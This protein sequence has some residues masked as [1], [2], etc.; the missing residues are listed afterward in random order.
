MKKILLTLFILTFSTQLLVA[1]NLKRANSLFERRA[2]LNAAELYLN[3]APKTQEIYQK[4]GDCYYF[5][6]KMK[7][8]VIYYDILIDNYEKTV[9]PT[10]LFRYSQALKG[11]GN[12]NKADK[13]L[14][15]YYETKQ[16]D[17]SDGLET[18]TYFETLNET[19]KR[20][21][22]VHSISSNS[23]KAM[24]PLL[25]LKI[26]TL[27]YIGNSSQAFTLCIANCISESVGV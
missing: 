24:F 2:Y 6:S 17:S 14:K 19:I 12:Y 5:N 1:Q 8:A 10:Y 25:S 27:A 20:P 7:Q 9:S 26:S 22:L 15:I 13:Y 23:A 18:L 3:E 16:L 21:Y 4:L 11:I